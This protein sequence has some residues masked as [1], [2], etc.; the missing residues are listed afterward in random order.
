MV[1]AANRRGCQNRSGH[2]NRT[3]DHGRSRVELEMA[4]RRKK[5][6]TTVGSGTARVETILFP[7]TTLQRRNRPS[8]ALSPPMVG[9]SPFDPPLPSLTTVDSSASVEDLPSPT[10]LPHRPWTRLA[11]SSRPPRDLRRVTRGDL[12][13][14]SSAKSRSTISRCRRFRDLGRMRLQS[15]SATSRA[16]RQ[17]R[18]TRYISFHSALTPRRLCS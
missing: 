1:D 7:S 3:E 8:D 11:P 9:P 4:T 14:G 16:G 18:L 10:L 15:L 13:R 6:E 2:S 12:G 5:K 17:L